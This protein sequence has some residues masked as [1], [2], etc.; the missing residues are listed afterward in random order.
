MSRVP[1]ESIA[2]LDVALQFR[3]RNVS[4]CA[5]LLHLNR[6]GTDSV[7][8]LGATHPQDRAGFGDFKS[9]RRQW[10]AGLRFMFVLGAWRG[11]RDICWCAKRPFRLDAPIVT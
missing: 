8:Q 4:S 3:P 7:I 1:V 11:R 9:Q 2:G 10:R 5:V 6:A